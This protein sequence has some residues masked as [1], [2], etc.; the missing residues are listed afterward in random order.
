MRG[1]VETIAAHLAALGRAGKGLLPAYRL[2][3]RVTLEA[4]LASGR[5]DRSIAKKVLALLDAG[6][7][8]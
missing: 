3:A 7:A 1:D 6:V 5:I 8:S 2:A 4:A